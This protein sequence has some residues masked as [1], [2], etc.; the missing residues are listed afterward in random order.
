MSEVNPTAA[1]LL[2]FLHDGPQTGWDL[3]ARAEAMIGPFW[4]LTRS[5]VYRE[6]ARMAETGLVS[7]G[8]PGRR[9]A[10]PYE[11]TEA[12]RRAFSDW[13]ARGPGEATVRL[14][15]LLFVSLGRHMP[16]EQLA[17]M[18]AE[19]RRQQ[20][21]LLAGYLRVRAELTEAAADPYLLATLDFGIATARGTVRWIDRLP[22]EIRG[23]PE[24]GRSG[25]RA[26][27]GIRS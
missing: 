12:G 23:A 27:V 7:A 25:P 19:Q 15:L 20:A 2:G 8:T 21:E 10:L 18:L 6:L 1:S 13:A 24:G 14:P 26:P 11:I 9:E 4:S 16:R 22:E 5:Q 3:V 17:A